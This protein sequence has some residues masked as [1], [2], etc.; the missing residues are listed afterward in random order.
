D[1]RHYLH[2][3]RWVSV[4]DPRSRGAL[5]PDL[6][7]AAGVHGVGTSDGAAGSDRGAADPGFARV[8]V[9]AGRCGVAVGRI[10]DLPARIAALPVG[11]KL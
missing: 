9:T 7:G 11:R 2:P 10:P 1:V 5:V 8:G 6:C 3:V 4:D